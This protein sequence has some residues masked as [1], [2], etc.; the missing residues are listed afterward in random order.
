MRVGL[1]GSTRQCRFMMLHRGDPAIAVPSR[2][3]SC[4]SGSDKRGKIRQA[5][6][7]NVGAIYIHT[8]L[9]LV[10]GKP[11]TKVSTQ[12]QEKHQ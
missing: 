11:A 8:C 4:T 5:S 6:G 12:Q 9:L 10:V 1:V 3:N 7:T 2:L